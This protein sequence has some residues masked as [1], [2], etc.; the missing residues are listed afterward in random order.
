MLRSRTWPYGAVVFAVAALVFVAAVGTDVPVWLGE[1]ASLAGQGLHDRFLLILLATVLVLLGYG[2]ARRRIAAYVGT[3]LLVAVGVAHSD[4]LGVGVALLAGGIVLA[5]GWSRFTALPARARVREAV[6][7]GGVMAAAAVLYETIGVAHDLPPLSWYSAIGLSVIV[8]LFPLLAAAPP[9]EPGTDVER[10]R[11]RELVANARSETLAPFALRTD[12]SYVFSADGTAA[13]G[14]RVLFGVAVVGGD[15]VGDPTA[16]PDALARFVRLCTRNGW[17]PAAL[18]AGEASLP[19]WRGHG[20]REV[21]YGDEVLLD[22]DTFTLSTRKMRNVRQAVH[23]ADNAGVT[24]RVV[25][26][27]ELSEVQREEVGA[28]SRRWLDG[29]RE[30]GFSM[31]LDGLLDGSQ[32]DCV[33]VLAVIPEAGGGTGEGVERVVGFQR[34]A[35][36]GSDA[37]LSLDVMRREPDAPNGLNERMIAAAVEYATA[38]EMRVVSL[39]FAAFRA[40]MDTAPADRT[41]AQRV[42][43]RVVHLLDPLIQVESLYTFNAKFRPRYLPRGAV[44]GSWLAVPTL[45]VALLGLE[46]A[47]PYDRR[48]AR[49]PGGEDAEMAPSPGEHG[50]PVR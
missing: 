17:R 33:F 46:F 24:T 45:L 37:G 23:R 34:Y 19:L 13:V 6:S 27:G 7:A 9:P 42:G 25:R 11:V 31:I 47:L 16:F 15:P 4:H 44:F 14:Y 43:Y 5:V 50:V 1:P 10:A 26:A 20:M 35:V 22:T 38:R 3:L 39:N 40:L 28:I 30:R 32:P 8:V 21:G 18:G 48:R 2:L 41:V 12:K 29:T 49:E 36:V